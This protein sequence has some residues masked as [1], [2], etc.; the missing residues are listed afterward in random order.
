MEWLK[1]GLNWEKRL[2]LLQLYMNSYLNTKYGRWQL[3]AMRCTIARHLTTTTYRNNVFFISLQYYSLSYKVKDQNNLRRGV[4]LSSENTIACTYLNIA[5]KRIVVVVVF[6][7]LSKSISIV[8]F[9]HLYYFIIVCL[10]LELFF[11]RSFIRSV[12]PA[13]NQYVLNTYHTFLVVLCM[14]I[15]ECIFC[16][17]N[18][19]CLCNKPLNCQSLFTK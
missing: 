12:V 3:L 15:H 13:F 11:L 16:E 6:P 1:Q 2:N 9:C 4:L 8:M 18:S 10:C 17:K 7:N 19:V 14:A 5:N